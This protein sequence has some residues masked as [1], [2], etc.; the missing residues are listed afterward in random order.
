[1]IS[2]RR[3]LSKNHHLLSHHCFL[4]GRFWAK[5]WSKGCFAGFYVSFF[6]GVGVLLLN[7]EWLSFYWSQVTLPDSLPHIFFLFFPYLEPFLVHNFPT[8][9]K[10]TNRC[11][12]KMGN[13][14]FIFIYPEDP[15]TLSKAP[16]EWLSISHQ[17]NQWPHGATWHVHR[18]VSGISRVTSCSSSGI[19]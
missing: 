5:I 9:P 17:Q 8:F 15:K 19:K 1:M 4:L 12:Q 14:V 11:P 2:S 18:Q 3:S 7:P 6:L 13:I 16:W 10:T